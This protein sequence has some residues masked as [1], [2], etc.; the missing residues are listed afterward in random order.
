MYCLQMHAY[1]VIIC[2]F[3]IA[4][5]LWPQPVSFTHSDSVLWLDPNV[6]IDY[7]CQCTVCGLDDLVS[8]A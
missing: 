7:E 6:T 3:A 5:A 2:F 1:L 8:L 4:G